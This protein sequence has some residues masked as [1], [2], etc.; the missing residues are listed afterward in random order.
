MCDINFFNSALIVKRVLNKRENRENV[1][2]RGSSLVNSIFELGIA[3]GIVGHNVEN[4]CG[5]FKMSSRR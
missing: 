4:E 5:R 2:Y 3:R 1:F